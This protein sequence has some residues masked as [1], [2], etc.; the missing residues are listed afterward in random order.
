MKEKTGVQNIVHFIKDIRQTGAVMPSSRYLARDVVDLLRKQLHDEHRRPVRVLELGAGTGTFTSH[1]YNELRRD[2]QLEV[3]ELNS[4]LFKILSQRFENI[5]NVNLHHCDVLNYIDARPY[6]Y[7][8]S[9]IPYE[10]IPERITEQIWDKKLSLCRKGSIIT[11]YKYI[12]FNR[13]RCKFEKR[14][15]KEFAQNEKVI[16]LNVPP[17]KIFSLHISNPEKV[18]KERAQN[19]ETTL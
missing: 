17:A 14:L 5:S 12:N 11:Y 7:I 10:T 2:D 6:D 19:S 9:S 3:V 1:I 18:I 16:F 8:Y 4:K 15:V 13:F